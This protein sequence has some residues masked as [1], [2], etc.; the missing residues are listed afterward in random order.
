[1]PGAFWSAVWAF[2][3]V[4]S[5]D[6]PGATAVVGAGRMAP[7][8]PTQGPRWFPA[9]RLSYAE[10]LLQGGPPDQLA[11]VAWDETGPTARLTFAELR[12]EVAR[13]ANGLAAAGV[14]AGD[15]VAGYLPNAPEAVVAMLAASA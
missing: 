10:N 14:G 5:D 6:G 7:P 12:D 8:D 9:A 13:F 3:R 11:L 4:R 1:E 2:C 15:R